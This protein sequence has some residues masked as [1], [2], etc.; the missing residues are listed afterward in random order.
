M[1]GGLRI[2]ENTQP[3]EIRCNDCKQNATG[4]ESH[5]GKRHRHCQQKGRWARLVEMQC[6][7]CGQVTMG[8]ELDFG[9]THEHCELNGH[10]EKPKK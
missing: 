2:K 6:N 10:W 7:G 1:K 4:I 9:T 8:I 5:I 3:V